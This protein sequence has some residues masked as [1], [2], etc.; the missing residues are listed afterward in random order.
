MEGSISCLY[1]QTY[2]DWR[3]SF[4][5]KGSLQTQIQW[6]SGASQ[7]NQPLHGTVQTQKNR[8]QRPAG[9]VLLPPIPRAG[10]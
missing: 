8:I 9:C 7:A 10:N 1:K 5:N 4:E 6:K 2:S 3:T